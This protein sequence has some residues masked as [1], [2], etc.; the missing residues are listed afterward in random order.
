MDQPGLL[1]SRKFSTDLLFWL[2]WVAASLAGILV[3]AGIL[4]GFIFLVAAI[5]PGI[6]EDRLA[7]WIIFPIVATLLGAA[8]ALVLRERIPRSGWWILS[9]T[10][11]LIGG[12]LLVDT[13]GRALFR[14]TDQAWA[15]NSQ[16]KLLIQY[17]FIG[18]FLGLAQIPVL[19]GHIRMPALWLLPSLLGWLA[20]GQIVGVSIDRRS[21][22]WAIGA[23]PA[24]FTGFGLIWLTRTSPRNGSS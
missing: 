19:V 5:I 18:L 20:L 14:G 22:V 13:A 2:K 1:G 17:V 3:G 21:D 10:A 7:G 8:Q 15:W 4:F 12:I 24:L 6:N 11:G 16:P 9:T 23:I